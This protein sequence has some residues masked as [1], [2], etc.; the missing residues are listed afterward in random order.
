MVTGVVKVNVKCKHC[1][2]VS[3]YLMQ[4]KVFQAIRDGGDI[5]KLLAPVSELERYGFKERVCV[6]C[7]A[8]GLR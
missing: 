5:D 6:H 3:H 4:R 8:K 1:S 7:L 2:T